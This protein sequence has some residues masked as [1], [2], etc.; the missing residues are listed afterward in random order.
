MMPG[1]GN[2]VSVRP[3]DGVELSLL[4]GFVQGGIQ[5]VEDIQDGD[6][7]RRGGSGFGDDVPGE[8][9]GDN[10]HDLDRRVCSGH[11]KVRVGDAKPV[12]VRWEGDVKTNTLSVD[13][14][15]MKRRWGEGWGSRDK[16]GAGVVRNDWALLH[17]RKR[18]WRQWSTGGRGSKRPSAGCQ[19]CL[20][21]S[22][23]RGVGGRR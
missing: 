7:R 23:R 10:F 3:G 20:R 12:R 14:E 4:N 2:H 19:R 8:S 21:V 1:I 5:G 18:M 11:R 17:R 15:V 9:G 22:R 16:M 13:K 6:E